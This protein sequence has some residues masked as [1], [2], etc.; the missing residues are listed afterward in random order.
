MRHLSRRVRAAVMSTVVAAAALVPALTVVPSAWAAEDGRSWSVVPA[1]P[2]GRTTAPRSYFILEGEPGAVIKDE[3]LIQN[4]TPHPI[5]FVLFGADAYNTDGAGA[6]AL[7]SRNDEQTDVGRW[8]KPAIKRITVYGE[9]AAKI[10]VTFRI[11]KDATPGDH[12]G[13]VVA[14]NTAIETKTEG[15]MKFGLQRAIAARA[16]VRVA[17]NTSPGFEVSDVEVQHDRG[18]WP[19]SGEGKGSVT[20]TVKNTGN[21]RLS[22]NGDVTVEGLGKDA[23]VELDEIQDLLPGSE[24]RLTRDITTIPSMGGVDVEVTLSGGDD[25]TQSEETSFFLMPWPLLVL[26]LVIAAAAAWWWKRRRDQTRQ[27]LKAAGEAPKISV[28]AGV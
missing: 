25:L 24:V 9:T 14:L 22:L 17:G 19:W 3:V 1:P 16:Y 4:W 12:A 15:D 7:R 13:G 5:T 27:R 20:Y 26:L 23:V 21:L 2:E 18:L 6:F 11:P 10:P 8:I 28:T